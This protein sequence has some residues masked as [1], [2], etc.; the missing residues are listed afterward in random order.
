MYVKHLPI[1]TDANI[2]TETPVTQKDDIT[3]GTTRREPVF[4]KP[5]PEGTVLKMDLIVHLPMALMI[6]VNRSTTFGRC[7]LSLNHPHQ[8]QRPQRH[9]MVIP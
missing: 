2:C 8:F 3:Y 9:L 5:I 6:Y 4:M 1:L 7:L